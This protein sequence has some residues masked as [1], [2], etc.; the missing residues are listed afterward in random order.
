M[1]LR[2]LEYL[3]A[4][5]EEGSFTRAAQRERV[6][7]PAVSAQIQRLERQVGLPLLTRSRRDVRLTQAGAAMLPHARAALAAVRA[8]QQ[9]VD[10]VANLVR[11]T[12]AIGTVTLHPVDVA[13]LMARFHGE[14]PGV[15]ISLRTD[16]SDVLLAELADGRLDATIVSIGV[17]EAPEGLDWAVITDEIIEPAVSTSH[18]LR[19]RKTVSLQHLCEHPLISLPPGT[20]LRSRLDTV[21]AAAGLRPKIAFEA[22]S[23]AELA[24]LARHGLGVAILP[25]SMARGTAGLHPLRLTPNLRGRLVWAWRRE[26]T[27]PAARLFCALACRSIR[28]ARPAVIPDESGVGPG[29]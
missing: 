25:R 9:A 17:D 14:H 22:S 16:N 20:G 21:C 1:E 15:E 23:P 13:G 24:E 10:E 12:V 18:P 3:V 8:A 5:V 26:T 29:A 4:V 28:D 27:S 2:Q 6:A 7:Q 11:G 19:T